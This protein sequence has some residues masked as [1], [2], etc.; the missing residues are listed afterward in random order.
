[1]KKEV[2]EAEGW[3]QGSVGSRSDQ[4]AGAG[5]QVNRC[6]GLKDTLPS[7]PYPPF[8]VQTP[9]LVE[10]RADARGSWLC[11]ALL[12]PGRA[13]QSLLSIICTAL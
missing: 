13:D 12:A 3:G 11:G 5:E 10:A 1:M 9:L 2:R 7:P 6:A 8:H 4:M